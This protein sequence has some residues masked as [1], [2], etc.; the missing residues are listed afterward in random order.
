MLKLIFSI[1]FFAATILDTHAQSRL[2]SR[3]RFAELNVEDQNRIII[4]TMEMMVELE[5]KFERQ[6]K[7]SSYNSRAHEEFK[8]FAKAF[9]DLL[10]S[11]AYAAPARQWKD[12]GAEFSSL[13]SRANGKQCVYAGW[14]SQVVGQYCTHPSLLPA[15]SSEKKAYNQTS[16]P[17]VKDISCNPVIFGFKQAS[18]ESLFCV[19]AGIPNDNAHNSALKCMQKALSSEGD[20][21]EAR[22][23]FLRANLLKPENARIVED[24]YKYLNKTCVCPGSNPMNQ[25][26]HEY[27]L[28]HRTCYGLMNMLATTVSCNEP[29]ANLMDTSFFRELQNMTVPEGA[30]GSGYDDFYKSY[31]E[32]MISTKTQEFKNLC[33]EDALKDAIRVGLKA[34]T[35][36]SGSSGGAS[37]GSQSGTSTG[38]GN[39]GDTTGP[40]SGSS[41]GTPSGSGPADNGLIVSSQNPTSETAGG[42][43]SGIVTDQ[44]TAIDDVIPTTPTQT[45]PAQTPPSNDGVV[46]EDP[47]GPQEDI[48]V[49]GRREPP[50]VIDGDLELKLEPFVPDFS[51]LPNFAELLRDLDEDAAQDL[52]CTFK[53][54]PS[55]DGTPA[56]SCEFLDADNKP[57]TPVTVPTLTSTEAAKP[58]KI[59]TTADGPERSCTPTEEAKKATIDLKIVQNLPGSV[60]VSA[61]INGKKD[62]IPAPYEGVV[63]FRK[64]AEGLLGLRTQT[65]DRSSSPEAPSRSGSGLTLKDGDADKATPG[66][67]ADKPEGREPSADGS[68]TATTNADKPQKPA[69]PKPGEGEF[70]PNRLEVTENKT[71]KPYEVCIKVLKDGEE[72]GMACAK[73]PALA[74]VAAPRPQQGP[75][76]PGPV[77]NGFRNGIR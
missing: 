24:V 25:K 43:Q 9:Q 18:K 2:I 65:D 22:L 7:T 30:T 37:S 23:A 58:V 13:I 29:V 57:M 50:V 73:V 8:K 6:V 60:V 4:R 51:N 61:T 63:W 59:K 54:K 48:V 35:D 46:V 10:I 19:P 70:K 44:P 31:L 67:E 1:L 20:G 5:A 71:A 14:V 34:P 40:N 47:T 45:T 39:G 76:M 26:Y 27:M 74:P 41:T 62:E 36:P 32:K 33:G 52:S 49:V 69:L 64:G 21:R 75:R 3:E 38:N 56:M 66:S 12:Y 16:C 42:A 68:G 77:L 55:T 72:A 11:S 53:C 17:N 28:P 15:S